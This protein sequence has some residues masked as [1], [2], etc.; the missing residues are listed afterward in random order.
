[1]KSLQKEKNS[2][3][4]S[5]AE[6]I[7]EDFEKKTTTSKEESQLKKVPKK[8]KK[9][10]FYKSGQIIEKRNNFQPFLPLLDGLNHGC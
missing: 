5:E 8:K 6:I 1:M 7:K 9:R 3:T 10:I 4:N 2:A